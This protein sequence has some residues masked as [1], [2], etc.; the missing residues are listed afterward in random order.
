MGGELSGDIGRR[1][2]KTVIP[3]NNAARTRRDKAL[4]LRYTDLLEGVILSQA[5]DNM[6]SGT[7]TMISWPSILGG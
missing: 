3:L 6:G 5:W 2:C 7:N 1:G 4:I